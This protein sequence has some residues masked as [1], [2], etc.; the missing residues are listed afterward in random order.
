MGV[1][2]V[3]LSSQMEIEYLSAEFQVLL[4]K[5]HTQQTERVLL[6]TLPGSKEDGRV[7]TN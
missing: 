7:Q 5:P 1:K 4:Q 2:E 6:D 3:N